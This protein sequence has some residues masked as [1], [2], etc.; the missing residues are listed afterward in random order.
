MQRRYM[1]RS[2]IHEARLQAGTVKATPPTVTL[3]LNEL[4]DGT[5]PLVKLWMDP[6]SGLK[7]Q[8]GDPE[9]LVAKPG[10]VIVLSFGI[11]ATEDNR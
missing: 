11:E 5:P 9:Q 2:V 1:I 4:E 8:Y 3:S 7:L 10:Q 6:S